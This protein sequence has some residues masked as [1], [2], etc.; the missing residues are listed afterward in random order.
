MTRLPN[1]LFALLGLFIAAC[2]PSQPRST[3]A[4]RADTAPSAAVQPPRPEPRPHLVSSPSGDRNDEYYWL[5]DDTRSSPEVLALLAQENAYADRQLAHIADAKRALYQEIVARIPPNDD[6]VPVEDDGYWYQKRFVEDGEYPLYVRRKGA[7]DGREEVL[8]DGNQLAQGHGFF[9]ISDYEVSPDTRVLAWAEDTMGRMQHTL[10]FKDLSRGELLPDVISNAEAALAWA[11]DSQTLLYIEKDPETL[12][13]KRVRKHRLG[14][15]PRLDPVVYEEPDE[16]FYLAVWSSRSERF[17]N[18]YAISTVSSEQW[19]ADAN[20]PELKFRVLIP[21]QRDHEYLAQDHAD[22]WVL[23]S[24]AGAPNFRLLTVPMTQVADRTRWRDLVAEPKAGLIDDFDVFD[25]FL[26][27]SA[28]QD[29]LSRVHVRAWASGKDREIAVPE[30]ASTVTLGDNREAATTHL[31]YEYT[32]LNTPVST[33]QYEPETARSELLK[34]ET[35]L[36]SFQAS[37]YATEYLRV[38]ARDG[39]VVPVS[40]VYRKGFARDGSAPLYQTAYGAYGENSDPEFDSAR[41]SLLNRGVVFAIAHVR[42]GQELGRAWYDQGRLLNKQRTFSDFV[43]V[44]RSLVAQGYTASQRVAARGASAGGLLMGAIANQAAGDYRV[45]V[46]HVPFVDVVTT[47]LDESIPLTTNEWDE[48]GDPRQ[49]PFYEAML[50]YSPY[51]NVK[52][53]AYPALY[54][55]T[56]LWDSQVQ[57][58]EPLKWVSRLR[59]KKTDDQPVILRVNMEAGHGGKSGRF[60]RQ[61]QIAEEYAFVLHELGVNVGAPSP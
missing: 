2:G 48:W 29:G 35:V 15:D 50:A 23:R 58:Y 44:T 16:S 8:L 22:Q 39:T 43:D 38:A 57:Y 36:G 12:L 30:P 42:G 13:G 7:P 10:R 20:D 5:R 59:A 61:Q 53:Q 25:G 28:H 18:I 26:A 31:R 24:N 56:G 4:A 33:L 54:V 45:I 14:T 37:D 11:A 34:Q 41:L 19:V 52:A 9:R 49:K 47:M 55:T 3:A 46:A 6:S 60:V 21:R 1:L 51:D 40:L 32:S 27:Y 17:L